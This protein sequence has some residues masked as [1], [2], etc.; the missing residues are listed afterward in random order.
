VRDLGWFLLV[1]SK[2]ICDLGFNEGS[3]ILVQSLLITLHYPGIGTI[4]TSPYI[5]DHKSEDESCCDP[6]LVVFV[7]CIDWS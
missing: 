6:S 3:I 1:E 7:S 2:M 5:I 4:D